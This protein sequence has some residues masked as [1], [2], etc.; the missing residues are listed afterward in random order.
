MRSDAAAGIKAAF[1]LKD[2]I[3]NVEKHHHESSGKFDFI[4][5]SK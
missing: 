1:A 5:A 4:I 2:G 3:I